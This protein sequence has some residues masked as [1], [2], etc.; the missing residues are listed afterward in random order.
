[1]SKPMG[2]TALAR[3][4]LVNFLDLLD[5]RKSA[6]IILMPIPVSGAARKRAPATRAASPATII[7]FRPAFLSSSKATRAL[8][9][10]DMSAGRRRLE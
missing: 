9:S 5:G 4:A 2:W 7:H 10:S 3:A 6:A 8:I 1:M